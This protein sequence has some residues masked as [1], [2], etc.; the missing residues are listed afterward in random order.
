MTRTKLRPAARVLLTLAAGLFLMYGCR[1][2]LIEVVILFAVA[3]FGYGYWRKFARSK[4]P[5]RPAVASGS[6]VS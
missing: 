6:T 4:T 3:R 5:V 1:V 2:G